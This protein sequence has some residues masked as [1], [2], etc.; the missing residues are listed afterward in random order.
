MKKF[1]LTFWQKSPLRDGRGLTKSEAP[2][3]LSRE[4]RLLAYASEAQSLA[5][6][7]IEGTKV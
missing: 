4:P 1:H 5:E 3:H 7:S 6:K 2:A